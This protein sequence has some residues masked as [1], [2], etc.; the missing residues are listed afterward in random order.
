MLKRVW[1]R[2]IKIAHVIGTVQMMIILTVLFWIAIAPVGIVFR[3]LSD[4]L[5]I[6]KPA[7]S[8]WRQRETPSGGLEFFRRQG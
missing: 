8:N 7:K 5:S 4:P 6:K 2:W 1:N 3:L